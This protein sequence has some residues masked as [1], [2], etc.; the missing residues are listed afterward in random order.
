MFHRQTYLSSSFRFARGINNACFLPQNE[1]AQH[2]TNSN[3]QK[4]SHKKMPEINMNIAQEA[5]NAWTEMN[6]KGLP[7]YC[8]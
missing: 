1:A 2:K 6:M 7:I 8:I 4:K 3:K 5:L